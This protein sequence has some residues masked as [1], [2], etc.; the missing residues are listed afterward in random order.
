LPEPLEPL[1]IVSHAAL[2]V[3]VQAQPPDVD[4]VA[5]AVPPGGGIT[6]TAGETAYAQAPPLWVTV[7]VRVATVSEP[8][9]DA[10]DVF[11]DTE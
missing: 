5:V 9:R 8:V 3:A 1:L 7:K 4:T 11:A 6:C 10:V 2:L